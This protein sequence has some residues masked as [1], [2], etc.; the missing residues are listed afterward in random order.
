M[1][2]GNPGNT[3]YNTLYNVDY[4]KE[5]GQQNIEGM[6]ERKRIAEKIK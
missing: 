6:K 1:K 2:F 5:Y 3:L 4:N